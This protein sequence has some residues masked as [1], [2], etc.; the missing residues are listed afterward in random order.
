[1]SLLLSACVGIPSSVPKANA[2]V[3]RWGA[4]PSTAT[5]QLCVC[6]LSQPFHSLIS[7]L[8]FNRMSYREAS[9]KTTPGRALR[10]ESSLTFS[11]KFSVPTPAY[12]AGG[13]S[14]PE[15]NELSRPRTGSSKKCVCVCA[16][17]RACVRAC[18]CRGGTQALCPGELKRERNPLSQHCLKLA[19]R[20]SIHT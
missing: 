1:M 8:S 2:V 11:S 15:S 7:N 3:R 9:W 14:Q 20:D 5:A 10:E 17:V 19:A 13:N 4:Q 12:K 18:V 16:C 6:S